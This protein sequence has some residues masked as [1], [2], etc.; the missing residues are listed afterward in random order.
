MLAILVAIKS[1]KNVINTI[2][3]INISTSYDVIFPRMRSVRQKSN[4]CMI[5]H[6]KIGINTYFLSANTVKLSARRLNS[7]ISFKYTNCSSC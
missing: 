6:Q 4:T 1:A 5:I 7:E 3:D 2:N